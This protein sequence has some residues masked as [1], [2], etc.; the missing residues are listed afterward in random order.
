MDNRGSGINCALVTM[1]HD[2]FRAALIQDLL[3]AAHTAALTACAHRHAWDGMVAA[4][5]VHLPTQV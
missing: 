1:H 4:Q 2:Q 5:T 3:H